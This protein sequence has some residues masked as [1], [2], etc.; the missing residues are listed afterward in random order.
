MEIRQKATVEVQVNGDEAKKEMRA[1]ESYAISLKGRLAEAY[2]VGDAKKAKQ[3][4]KELRETNVQLKLMR[5]NARNIDAAM[6]NIGL[7]TPKELRNLIRDINTKLSSGHVKRGSAEWKQYQGQLKLVNNELKRVKAEAKESQGWLTRFND[8]FT[9]WG[10]LAAST[11]AGVTGLTFTIRKA[12]DAYARMEEA[13]AQ[14]VKYTG[15]TKQQVHELNE[16]LKRMDTRTAREKLNALAGD[17]GRLGIS[18]KEDVLEFVDAADKINVALGEDLGEDAVKNIGKLAM[19]FGEDRKLGLRGAMLATG[20]AINEVAQNSSAA[21]AYLV[22]FMG[23]VSGA[24]N[25]AKVA[26]GDIIGYASVLDQNMQ[27]QEMAATAFQTLMMKM[28]QTPAK[29]AK[30]AGKNVQ[31]F[32]A[33]IKE[34]ANEAI[35]QFL[36][37]LGKKGGL[38][39]LAPMFKE[40]K[41]DGVRAAGVISTMAGKIEDI[42]AAQKLAN[43]AYS[44]GTSIINE[45]N[46]QNNTVQA[47]ID[48]AKKKF[49]DITIELGEK[50]LPIARYGISTGSL[51]VKG[52]KAI[53]DILSENGVMIASISA[54]WL[55]Y[56][57]R[58]K[59]ATAYHAVLNT[60]IKTATTVQ[61]AY[62]LA[63]IALNDAL[64]G[65]VRSLL[66]FARQIRTANVLTK[67]VAASTML[68]RAAVELLTFR[69]KGATAALK[70]FAIVARTGIF[71]LLLTAVTAAGIAWMVFSKRMD[72]AAKTQRLLNEIQNEATIN[73]TAEREEVE[74]LLRV[75]KDETKTK[76]ERLKAI[77]RLN[78]ISPEYLGALDLETIG[79]D[80]A[81]VSVDNYVKS[82][83]VLAEIEAAKSRL[84][85]TDKEL[86]ELKKKQKEYLDERETFWGAVKALPRN[87]G[88]M[89]T[90]GA[91]ED[92]GEN[93]KNEIKELEE[94]RETLKNFLQEQIEEKVNIETTTGEDDKKCPKCGNFPCTCKE[95]LS[96]KEKRR[97]LKE[98]L[99]KVE[100]AAAKE[101]ALIKEKYARG[102]TAYRDYCKAINEN[103]IKE[104]DNKMALYDQESNEYNQLLTKKQDLLRKGL[105]QENKLT[106]DEIEDCAKKEE[107]AWVDAYHNRQISRYALN[108]ALFMLDIAALSDKQALYA[109]DSKEWYDYERQITDLENREKIRKQEGYQQL[110]SSIREKYSK[111]DIDQLMQEEIDGIDYLHE[112]GLLKEEEYQKLLRAVKKKFLKEKI[113]QVDN[114]APDDEST[115][116]FLG[117]DFQKL[118]DKYAL[119]NEA[120]EQGKI[121]H[122]KALQ[123]K[124]EADAKYLDSLKAKTEA[125]YSSLGS[126]VTAYSNYT[127]ACQ[128]LEVAKIEKKYDEEIKAAGNNTVKTKKLEE[129]KEQEVAKVKSKYNKKAMKMEIAQAFAGMAMSAINAYSSAAEV[130]LV[131]YILAPIAATAAVAAG[132]L[133]IATIKK[134]H[135]AQE[136]G[137]Y[138]GGF[139]PLGDPKKEVGVVHAN[140]FVANHSAVNNP[141]VLPVLRLIDYAQKNNTIGSLT[142]EDISMSLNKGY[143]HTAASTPST[144]SGEN[145]A[146][147]LG[148][149]SNTLDRAS[150]VIEQLSEKLNER[151]ESYVTIDGEHGFEK[152]YNHYKKLKANKSR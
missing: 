82:L 142:A 152:Q 98:N 78:E 46:V 110:L 27:Q 114:P 60:V 8:G 64:A 84:T 3:L 117:G 105:D 130:P 81:R 75:A 10:A 66:V 65:D 86:G 143:S 73:I 139:T 55:I 43:D 5:T 93:L 40:M 33:L 12:T 91:V 147:L 39:K 132:M 17:A 108:E 9:K 131:G 99:K 79:T 133:Q 146:M 24:A 83:L 94:Q 47:G 13:E 123:Q 56:V 140:E 107:I 74:A 25:Q 61:G 19:M 116:S 6:N 104:L 76:E 144:V 102:E 122:Q 11:I 80:K 44:D 1:L 54:L 112:N 77:K 136:A 72:A 20:S 16:D 41:L 87:M 89:L 51:A 149:V 134:Q 28:Y 58:L 103:D 151:I 53:F 2:K 148:V 95:E 120:E 30:L 50:L 22:G 101:E 67:T 97:R 137:Y 4:E 119:I 29:F 109:K 59:L 45:F 90:F 35:L 124:A 38:D 111:K 68:Y 26:Q 88:S 21:E 96:E 100:A 127:N 135:Q 34:D 69:L 36:E 150:D 128:D 63:S 48:K 32:T 52:L 141:N 121:T 14:V 18:A 57:T 15:M 106:I 7:A 92:T 138:S 37:T 70:G 42:R 115:Q 125:V 62:R 71:G 31:E 145:T 23:R 126:I 85:D 49:A 118:K 113:D 129:K